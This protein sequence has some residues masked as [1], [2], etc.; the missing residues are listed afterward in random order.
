MKKLIPF[1][2][3]L[4]QFLTKT[5]HP[6]LVT[7]AKLSSHPIVQTVSTPDQITSIFDTISYNKVSILLLGPWIEVR[8]V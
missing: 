6:V 8:L 5:V 7:D 3:Q 1:Y 4:D 2:L